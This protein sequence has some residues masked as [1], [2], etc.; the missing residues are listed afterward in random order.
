M[1]VSQICSVCRGRK[2]VIGMGMMEADCYRCHGIGYID[3][4]E[5]VESS[6][7]LKEPVNSV[8]AQNEP[9]KRSR[10][11]PPKIKENSDVNRSTQ[12]TH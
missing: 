10:G 1:N 7:F 3:L 11:R 9:V 8:T 2:K 6:P 12:T 4:S 5:K